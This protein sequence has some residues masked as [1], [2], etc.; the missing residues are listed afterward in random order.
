MAYFIRIR[1]VERWKRDERETTAIDE[2]RGLIKNFQ[3]V[4]GPLVRDRSL[5]LKSWRKKRNLDAASFCV[6]LRLNKLSRTRWAEKRVPP[7][8]R[9]DFEPFEDV[10]AGFPRVELKVPRYNSII[11]SVFDFTAL[12]CSRVSRE[13]SFSM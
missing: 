11:Q 6:L 12:R 1:E 5:W 8:A 2:D 9:D 3:L 13:N 4:T 7:A 10:P